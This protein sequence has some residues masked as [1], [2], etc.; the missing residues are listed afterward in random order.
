MYPRGRL[1]NRERES[2]VI[3]VCIGRFQNASYRIIAQPNAGSDIVVKTINALTV[4]QF[5]FLKLDCFTPKLCRN[6]LR[7]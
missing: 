6:F 2:R 3:S 7:L 5:A 4:I 1:R